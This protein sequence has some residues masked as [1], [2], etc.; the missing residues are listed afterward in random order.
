MNAGDLPGGVAEGGGGS[1]LQAMLC[2]YLTHNKDVLFG[3]GSSFVK[4]R[5]IAK[6]PQPPTIDAVM[7][8]AGEVDTETCAA[9]LATM[10]GVFKKL[11]PPSSTESTDRD[12][13]YQASLRLLL[14]LSESYVL[15]TEAGNQYIARRHEPV[16]TQDSLLSCVLAA[17]RLGFGLSF[18]AGLRDPL[19]V[20]DAKPAATEF[21]NFGEAGCGLVHAEALAALERLFEGDTS[22]ATEPAAVPIGKP[23]FDVRRGDLQ[24]DIRD[25]LG[26]D[27]VL[28]VEAVGDYA[29]E[30]KR[31]A[32]QDYLAPFALPTFFR[33]GKKD[34]VP[35][36][37]V[38]AWAKRVL[39]ELSN[40]FNAA[41]AASINQEQEIKD[42]GNQDKDGASGHSTHNHFH[43]PVEQVVTGD[44]PQVAGRDIINHSPVWQEVSG[45]LAALRAAI[46]ALPDATPQKKQLLADLEDVHEVVKTGKPD[47]GQAKLV[48]R[49]LDGLKQGAEAVENGSTIVEKL[50]PAA[51]AL[52]AAWPGIVSWIS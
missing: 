1:V 26:A 34:A 42:M 51:M 46:V 41:F 5:L 11:S 20:V 36:V 10:A 48:K 16:W 3:E 25:K 44:K 39:G 14:V 2:D 33:A 21:G 6:L 22:L 30:D 13:A 43:G 9:R 18:R 52:A 4:S 19:N 35:E 7:A 37:A 40:V 8:M 49:C 47:D 15:S 45:S 24:D 17:A 31:Q 38:P 32:L 29:H 27:P 28:R 12:T 50:G 23:Y